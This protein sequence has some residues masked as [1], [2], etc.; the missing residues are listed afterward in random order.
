MHRDATGRNAARRWPNPWRVVRPRAAVNHQCRLRVAMT[1]RIGILAGLLIADNCR[2]SSSRTRRVFVNKDTDVWEHPVS[3]ISR[4]PAV[5]P[6]TPP[7]PRHNDRRCWS[8]RVGLGKTGG[9]LFVI[10]TGVAGGFNRRRARYDFVSRAVTDLT[11]TPLQRNATRVAGAIESKSPHV[12]RRRHRR[13][14]E[15]R[16]PDLPN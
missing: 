8:S 6:T 2:S 1:R 5:L 11:I 12:R 15:L 10:E 13:R 7:T 4:L 9:G 14:I 16:R 3:F